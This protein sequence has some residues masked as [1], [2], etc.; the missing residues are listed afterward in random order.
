MLY[1]SMLKE[2]LILQYDMFTGQPVDNRT[3]THGEPKTNS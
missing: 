1:L 3:P 2:G